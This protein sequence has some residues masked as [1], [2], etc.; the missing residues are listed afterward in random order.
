MRLET[1][2][3]RNYRNYSSLSLELNPNINLFFGSNA[4]GKTNLLESVAFIAAGR[5]FRTRNE[6]ELILWGENNCTASARVC[7]RMGRET[8][9]VSFDV[10]SRNKIFSVNGLTM[11]RSNYAGRLVTVLFTPEDLSIVKGSPAVRRKFFDD[12]ISK[13]LPVYEYELGRLQQIIRQRNNL[14]KKFRQK[15]LG[16]QELA[17]WNEQLAILSAKI[18]I[19]R[20]TA[21]R[22]IG[23]LARLSHRNLTGR[24][25]SLEI[26]YQSFLPLDDGVLDTQVIQDALL[27]GLEEKKHEEAR[28][29]QTLL[30]PHR[31]DIVFNINGR[32]ARLYASQ[33]Q[34]RTLVLALKLAELEFIKG[35]T[36]EYPVLLFDDVF[37]ELDERRRRLLVETIDGRIQTFITGTEAEKL[38]QF[39]ESGKMFKVREGEVV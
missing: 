38:R 37:S 6:G 25:E 15:V 12:E 10:G 4:Q 24:D 30:G 9:K 1:I 11:N 33:G 31:D 21:I 28:L 7:N 3:L 19:K 36:G 27:A 17:S 8:L 39:K 34:Q 22:R 29:G 32:N 16:S 26:L 14:L 18:L 2:E 13:I 35:E 5:S 23:L 20:V